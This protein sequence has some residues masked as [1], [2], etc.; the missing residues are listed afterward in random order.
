MKI[1]LFYSSAT[2][3][4][5]GGQKVQGRMWKEG[6]EALGHSVDLISPFNV[7]EWNSYDRFIILGIGNLVYDYVQ[8]LKRFGQA[9]LV[10]APIIDW[11]KSIRSFRMR[12]KYIGCQRLKIHKPLNDYYV[13]RNEFSSFLVRSEHEKL[14]LTEGLGVN[15]NRVHLVPI[16]LRFSTSEITPIDF[17]QK[18][19]FCLHVSRLA[20]YEKNVSR[21]IL[22]AKKYKFNLVLA[23]TINGAQEQRWLDDQ[24]CNS[25]NIQYV[26]RLSDKELN[27]Y[28][29][30]AKVFALPSLIEGVGMVALEAAVQGAEI[31][32]TNLGAPKEYYDGR[33][34][35]VNPLDVDE[36][37]KAVC[38]ALESGKSQPELREFILKNY[39]FERCSQMLSDVLKS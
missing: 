17:G 33:A 2:I 19:N 34:F 9:Q 30:R 14:F 13:C 18:D 10:S 3:N 27:D 24:I 26:G 25:S 12:A 31:V 6:L 29:R 7:Y 1:A 22:A 28:Y 39:S 5:Y 16:S 8:L 36:I 21:L 4:N 11:P 37:G 20:S 23:G 32:L 35:L 38:S 15:E